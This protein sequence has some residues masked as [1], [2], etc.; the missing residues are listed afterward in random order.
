MGS[1]S[2]I[3]LYIVDISHYNDIELYYDCD[4]VELYNKVLRKYTLDLDDLKAIN[5]TINYP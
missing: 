4:S 1:N 5:F 2:F 3:E